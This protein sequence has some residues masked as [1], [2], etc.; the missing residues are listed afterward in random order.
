MKRKIKTKGVSLISLRTAR[1]QRVKRR[2]KIN[3]S[4]RLRAKNSERKRKRYS[5]EGRPSWNKKDTVLLT[6]GSQESCQRR[7]NPRRGATTIF[8][9]VNV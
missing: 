3:P 5:L 4:K 9:V 8:R 6:D 1:K 7:K 2:I